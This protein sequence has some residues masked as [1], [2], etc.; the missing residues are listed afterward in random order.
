ME[1]QH[2]GAPA[3]YNRNVRNYLDIPFG[4]QWI[5][6]DGPVCWPVRSP[7]LSCLNFYFWGYMKTL[8]YN[9]PVDNAQEPVARIAVAAGEIR[10]MPGVFQNVW[11]SMCRRCEVCIVTG[12]RNFEH[13][14]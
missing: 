10:D 12:R 6:R 1:F 8:I 14:L 13:L 11:I 3:H 2:D 5:G 9:I 7:D 4:Q